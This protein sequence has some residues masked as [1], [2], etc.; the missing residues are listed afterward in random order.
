MLFRSV[1]TDTVPSESWLFLLLA[2]VALLLLTHP[3]RKNKAIDGIRL[4][5]MLLVP[6]LLASVALYRLAPQDGYADNMN[7]LQKFLTTYFYTK[8]TDSSAPGNKPGDGT[9][10]AQSGPRVDL[11]AVGSR[12]TNYEMVM[13]VLA[14]S[15][16]TLYLRDRSYD[17]YDGLNWKASEKSTGVDPYWPTKDLTNIGYVHISTRVQRVNLLLPY[18]I[19][20]EGWQYEFV[21]GAYPN[22][23]QSEYSFYQKTILEAGAGLDV[24]A[25]YRSADL[26]Q[27]LQIP[28]QTKSMWK[29]LLANV[30]IPAGAEIP[31]VVQCIGDY[32]RSSAV[33]DL[34]A[35]AMPEDWEDFGLWFLKEGESGYC[36]HFA[37]AATLLLRAKG[38]P[39]RY[40]TGYVTDVQ[41]GVRKTVTGNEGH[42]WV[43]YLDP[44]LGWQILEATPGFSVATPMPPEKP[45]PTE[46]TDPQQTDPAETTEPTDP[47]PTKPTETKP[48]APKETYP[49]ETTAPTEATDPMG[50]GL[51]GSGDGQGS[52]NW[53]QMRGVILRIL[54]VLLVIFL[55]IGQRSIRISRRRRRM[56]K[57]NANQQARARWQ[58]A[59]RLRRRTGRRIP[60]SLLELA[61]KAAYSQHMLTEQELA[62]LDQ[63]LESERKLL[64]ARP[65]YLRLV[66]KWIFAVL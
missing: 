60:E 8:P 28:E 54:D 32:V 12:E 50:S 66:Y 45:T 35:E 9:G 30:D 20:A 51:I 53:A 18:Y 58:F 52:G 33:Y 36:I 21:E 63:W 48:T 4:T 65:W 46:P 44:Q 13:D 41:R 61:E 2:S 62:Q 42:A 49:K 39:A 3:V 43:E 29:T 55:V 38:I 1:V 26:Q 7:G 40:V 16:Q 57:G 14:E 10:T 22:T 47:T 37:T 17:A 19:A 6:V 23:K 31:E 24:P 34:N 27:Y 56:R 59:L 64:L 5:A 25:D 15:T 11:A